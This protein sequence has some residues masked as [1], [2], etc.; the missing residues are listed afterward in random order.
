MYKSRPSLLCRVV[1]ANAIRPLF[2]IPPRGTLREDRH[3]TAVVKSY[4][5]PQ[6]TF[7]FHSSLLPFTSTNSPLWRGG[8]RPGWS[9]YISCRSVPFLFILRSYLLLTIPLCGGVAEGRGGQI[10][11]PAVRYLFFSFFALTFCL[12]FPSVEGWLKAGVVIHS[13]PHKKERLA[14]LFL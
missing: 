10:I 3:E 13:S 2:Q 12:L 4:L 9:N 5:P 14:P 11:S 7:S 6:R 8:R 1:G